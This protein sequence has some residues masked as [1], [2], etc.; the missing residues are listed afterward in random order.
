MSVLATAGHVDHGKSTLVEALTGTHP[1]RWAVER[2]RGMTIDLGFAATTLPSG[3]EIS[4]VDVPGHVRYLR[5]MLAGVGAVSGA[6]VAV[7]AREGWKEQSEEHLVILATLGVEAV[8]VALTMADVT[9][10]SRLETVRSDVERRLAASP[11]RAVDVVPTAAPR[12]E[13]VAELLAALDRLTAALP[14]PPDRAAPRLWVDRAF[15]IAGSGTVVTGTLAHGPLRVGDE[16]VIEPSGRPARIRRL[17]RHGREVDELAAG[18]RAAVNLHR[19]PVDAVGRGDALV[20]PERWHVTDRVDATLHLLGTLGHGVGRRG[21]HS[22]HVGSAEI[23]A[24]IRVIGADRL[25]AGAHGI[26]RLHLSRPAP[27][28]PGDRY[29]LRDL[30]RGETLGGGE[31]LD[32]APVRPMSRARPDR[33]LVRVVAERGWVE[34]D[35][36][37]R[38]TGVHA[39][40][41]AGRWVID[42]SRAAELEST[43]RDR[44][45]TAGPGG[46][47]LADLPEPARSLATTLTD[48]AL[49]Q[50]RLRPADD[51]HGT[52]AGDVPHPVVALLE[53]RPFQ[54]DQPDPSV[55]RVVLR[56]LAGAGRI[57]ACGGIWFA[58]SAIEAAA[59]AV[60]DLLAEHPE[61]VTVSQV[62]QR[63]GTSRRYLLPLLAHLD[64]TGRT[65]RRGDVRLGGPRLP[66]GRAPG[67]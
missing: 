5:N 66:A 35:E 52:G 57:V 46:L 12:G 24:R 62:R 56:D 1:D 14:A 19:V 30:G 48:L 55:E 49:H 18:S 44:L 47:P 16:V 17:H 59:V 23:P 67:T 34:V 28:V 39:E 58:T 26:V 4:F 8:V 9:E 40:A 29:V 25:D 21:A 11:V 63:L 22:V 2:D 64:E 31:I 61:G 45:A 38:L 41:T 50:G 33:S 27:L 60:A 10:P 36:L 51:G 42:P 32:V 43:V 65:R 53:R 15:T 13:G 6:L 54:P 20:R 3:R 7:S 37:A